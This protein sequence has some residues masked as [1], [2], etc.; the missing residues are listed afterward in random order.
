MGRLVFRELAILWETGQQF[1][2][3]ERWKT[4]LHDMGPQVRSRALSADDSEAEL[5]ARFTAHE[6]FAGLEQL[7]ER[8][9]LEVLLQRRFL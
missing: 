3:L 8:A 5:L 6:L 7:D 1:E 4:E 9:F 2:D